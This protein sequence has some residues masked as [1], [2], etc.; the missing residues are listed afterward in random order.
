MTF[1]LHTPKMGQHVF[2]STV[3]KRQLLKFTYRNTTSN[4]H[5]LGIV[6]LKD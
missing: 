5:L 2:R 1:G 4:A 6:F 3:I